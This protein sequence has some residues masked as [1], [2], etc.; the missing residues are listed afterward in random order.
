MKQKNKVLLVIFLVTSLF[1]GCSIT[2]KQEENRM[3][4]NKEKAVE[5]LNSIQTGAT[6]PIAYVNANKYIQ[7]NL[8]VKDGLAGFSEVLSHLP[9]GSAKVEVQR[10]FEDENFVF[11]HTKYNFF[12]PKAGFDI[13]RFEDGKIVE[14][15]D[16]LQEIVEKTASGR[17][18][19]DG[20]AK[21]TDLDKTIENKSLIKDFIS[22]VLMGKNPSKITQYISTEK[23]IQHN[24][25][26]KDGLAGLGEAIEALNKANMPMVYKKNHMILGEGNFVLSV[27]EGEF[28]KKHVSFYDLF[29]IENNKIVEHWDT[30]EEIL[31]QDKWQNKNGKF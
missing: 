6:A 15:W 28:M 18:Q 29:R 11:T 12:G 2:N 31:S 13:F 26:V 14:H 21:I 30:I 16:N 17:T 3:L 27:S 24:P 25:H 4:T 7:H 5:L 10:S 23:Y 22:D 20:S 8:S 19:F 1:T 9:K